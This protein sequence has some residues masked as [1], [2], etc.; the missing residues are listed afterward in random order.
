MNVFDPDLYP[1]ATLKIKKVL[2][3]GQEAELHVDTGQ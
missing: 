3:S 2:F 1:V